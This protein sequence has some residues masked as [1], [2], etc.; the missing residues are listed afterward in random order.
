[1]AGQKSLDIK[2][3]CG[4]YREKIYEVKTGESF[5][6]DKRKKEFSEIKSAIKD[7]KDYYDANSQNPELVPELFLIISPELRG[8]ITEY[9]HHLENT[10]NESA[11]TNPAS[12]A[13]AVWLYGK[14]KG[15]PNIENS[16]DL[17]AFCGRIK[18]NPAYRDVQDHT[19]DA[20]SDMDDAIINKID[21]LSVLDIFDAKAAELE[22]PSADLMHSLLQLLRTYSGTGTDIFELLKNNIIDFFSRRKLIALP[23]RLPGIEPCEKK[24][25]IARELNNKCSLWLSK[26]QQKDAV[27][28]TPVSTASREGGEID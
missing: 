14:L 1:L 15:L 18:I 12:R 10:Q 16:S 3:V 4:S 28:P 11:G 25:E 6:M 19:N 26:D 17:L 8:K 5:A 24:R 13:S 2:L 9:Y 27:T 23:G 22:L 21:D 7:L 20:Y